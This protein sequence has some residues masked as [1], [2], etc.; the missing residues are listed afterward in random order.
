MKIGNRLFCYPVL[1]GG[2][3]DYRSSS[4]AVDSSFSLS[5]LEWL[6]LEFDLRLKCPEVEALIAARKASYAIHLECAETSFR[7]LRQS[8]SPHFEERLSRQQVRGA[9]ERIALVVLT[10]DMQGYSSADLDP[11]YD[12]ISFDLSKGSILAYGSLPILDVEPVFNEQAE[13]H[14]VFTVFKLMKKG[15]QPMNVGLDEQHIMIGLGEKEFETYAR[16]ALQP[17]LQPL[18][19][20]ALVFPALVYALEQLKYEEGIA[21]YADLAWF[22][23]LSRAYAQ[24]GSS[25]EE[26]LASQKSSIEIAQ[27]LMELPVSTALLSIVFAEEHEE[28][29]P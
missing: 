11:D 20:A 17:H 14:S 25:L 12:G 3:Q 28:E 4:F 7:L 2:S 13:G 5:G 24:Q 29:E 10:E 9:F 8:S 22:R 21:D 19:N 15:V 6:D 23:T 1:A 27:E 16:Y 18:L 26:E